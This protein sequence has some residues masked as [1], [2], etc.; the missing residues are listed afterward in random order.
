MMSWWFQ[1]LIII[2]DKL[3]QLRW[4]GHMMTTWNG[5]LDMGPNWFRIRWYR[6]SKLR[7]ILRKRSM[8]R[9]LKRLICSSWCRLV[10]RY[11]SFFCKYHKELR[12]QA[13]RRHRCVLI[14]NGW[15]RWSYMVQ[16]RQW[17]FM[18][19]DK[20]WNLIW[21]FYRNLRIIFLIIKNLNQI[22]F[23]HQQ[24]WILRNL[25]NR[26]ISRIIFWFYLNIN[27]RFLYR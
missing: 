5:F 6:R 15:I 19:M 3:F 7:R 17:R 23:L 1:Q 11:L 8:R 14:R 27:Q 4:L 2:R 20:R 22:R 18:G 10:F 12:Y 16:R 25:I 21:I 24:R 13:W 9:W 26:Y